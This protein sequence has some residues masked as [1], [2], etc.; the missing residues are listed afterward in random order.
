MQETA[1]RQVRGGLE[2]GSLGT[3]PG[4]W[5]GLKRDQWEGSDHQCHLLV[6]LPRCF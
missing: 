5:E 1:C 2:Q 4:W 3:A 6:L